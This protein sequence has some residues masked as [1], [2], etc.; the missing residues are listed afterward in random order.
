MFVAISSRGSQLA[1]AFNITSLEIPISSCFGGLSYGR[2]SKDA[3][4]TLH[5]NLSPG[6]SP[7]EKCKATIQHSRFERLHRSDC[8]D[9]S[10]VDIWRL[11]HFNMQRLSGAEGLER[12]EVL[13]D[14]G[15]AS[16]HRKDDRQRGQ[17]IPL[18]TWN[19]RSP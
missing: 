5:T 16:G 1:T 10:A 6:S 17:L 2:S 14:R 7:L 8:K 18:T 9:L 3:L 15:I 19:H 12:L 13:R 4:Q 11:E